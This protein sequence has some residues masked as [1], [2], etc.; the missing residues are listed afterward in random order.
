M[1]NCFDNSFLIRTFIFHRAIVVGVYQLLLLFLPLALVK[2]RAKLIIDG[3]INLR[4]RPSGTNSNAD[5]QALRLL[6]PTS[7]SCTV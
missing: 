5:L 2:L 7:S 1:I 4:R 3:A 6:T